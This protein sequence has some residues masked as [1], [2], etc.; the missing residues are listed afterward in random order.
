VVDARRRED[1]LDTELTLP[2]AFPEKYGDVIVNAMN[3]WTVKK[4]LH[5]PPSFEIWTVTADV[6][7]V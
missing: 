4:H 2:A 5:Q 7:A 3:L 6:A 1:V